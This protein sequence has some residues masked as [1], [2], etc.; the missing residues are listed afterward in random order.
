ME[1]HLV[2]FVT[3][4]DDSVSRLMFSCSSVVDFFKKKRLNHQHVDDKTTRGE[5]LSFTFPAFR[6]LF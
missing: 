4:D 2:G 6:E 1:T 3:F 5:E